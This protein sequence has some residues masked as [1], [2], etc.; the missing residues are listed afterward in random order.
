MSD[1]VGDA[2]LRRSYL[3]A[4]LSD[5]QLT[6]VRRNMAD[7]QPMGTTAQ[8]AGPHYPTG[9]ATGLLEQRVNRC[10]TR[11]GASCPISCTPA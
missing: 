6:V 8:E 1:E 11:A 4:D 10:S 7:I 5:K 2:E 9:R 3:F